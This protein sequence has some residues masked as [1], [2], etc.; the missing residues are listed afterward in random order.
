MLYAEKQAA[1]EALRRE[2]VDR[3]PD[4]WLFPT[5]GPVFGFLGASPV[6][7]VAERPSTGQ[8][9]SRADKLLYSLLEKLGVPD[10]HLTDVIKSR[11]RVGDPYPSDIS[12]HRRVF[13]RELA[14]VQ[15]HLI[16]AFGQKVYDLLQFTLAGGGAT[17]R[18][19]WHYSYTRRGAD[20]P[21][22]FEAQLRNAL[23]GSPPKR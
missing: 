19:V 2:I 15:P 17:I 7:L 3:I 14:I 5:R 12:E 4:A 9:E 8:F 11:G 23:D 10:A 22:A 1:L 16:I 21:A 13:E 6:M 18:T 20:K